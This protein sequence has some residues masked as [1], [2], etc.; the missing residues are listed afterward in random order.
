MQKLRD[1]EGGLLM[2][3]IDLE[4]PSLIDTE[5]LSLVS[6]ACGHLDFESAVT[7]QNDEFKGSFMVVFMSVAN[8]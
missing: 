7:K 4:C 6:Y 2:T 5:F 3:T 8:L 1:Y